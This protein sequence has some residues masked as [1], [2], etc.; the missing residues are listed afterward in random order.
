MYIA[1]ALLIA[2]RARDAGLVQ[3]AGGQKPFI[4]ACSLFAISILA[5][6]LFEGTKFF[7]MSPHAIWI[8]TLLALQERFLDEAQ[9]QR[10][11]SDCNTTG[12]LVRSGSSEL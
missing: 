9:A 8:W 7:A 4:V 11:R 1:F 10:P 5:T 3:V 6:E 2:R 12:I